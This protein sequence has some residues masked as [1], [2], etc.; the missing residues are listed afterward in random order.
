MYVDQGNVRLY[1][2]AQ[3]G[4]VPYPYSDDFIVSHISGPRLSEHMHVTEPYI[5]ECCEKATNYDE[6][7][8]LCRPLAKAGHEED[9]DNLRARILWLTTNTSKKEFQAYSGKSEYVLKQKI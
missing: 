6:F 4:N 2:T 7:I 5:H 9:L 8:E 3:N 1:E